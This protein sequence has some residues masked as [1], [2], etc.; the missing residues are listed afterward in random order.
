MK[1]KGFAVTPKADCPHVKT[2]NL[3]DLQ[4][5]DNIKSINIK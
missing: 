3:T 2:I 5:F 4:R 1:E